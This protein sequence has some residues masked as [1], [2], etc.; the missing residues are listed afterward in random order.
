MK[1]LNLPEARWHDRP[2][3][4]DSDQPRKFCASQGNK[5]HGPA[6][7]VVTLAMD[8]GAKSTA[9]SHLFGL[10]RSGI[11]GDGQII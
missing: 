8:N 4:G 3:I 11:A 6:I 10:R 7:G 9:S 1:R 5:D 2:F